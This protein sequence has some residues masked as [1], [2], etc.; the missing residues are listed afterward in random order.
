MDRLQVTLT[1]LEDELSQLR[2]D[3]QRNKTD[4]EQ[5]LRVKQNLEMEIATYRRLLEG[6]EVVK[7]TPPPPKKELDVRT[8]KIVKVVTQTM[9][10]GKVVDESSEVEQ[11]EEHKK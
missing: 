3:M 11:I 4:Y 10:N 2:L 9:V 6:E 1:Q 8:R 7:E 5:L